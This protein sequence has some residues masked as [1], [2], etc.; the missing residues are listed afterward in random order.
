MN[1]RILT[2][3]AAIGV[4]F[5]LLNCNKASDIR[6]GIGQ[7]DEIQVHFSEMGLQLNTSR[8]DSV[9][10]YDD[11]INTRS[12]LAGSISDPIFGITNAIIYTHF[13]PVSVPDFSGAELDSIV[14]SLAFDTLRK[15]YANFEALQSFY[16]F[17]MR[18]GLSS[19]NNYYSSDI[20]EVDPEP[21]GEVINIMPRLQD[22]IHPQIRIKLDNDFGRELLLY[23]TSVYRTPLTFLENFKGLAIFPGDPSGGLVYFDLNSDQTSLNLYYTKDGSELLHQIRVTLFGVKMNRFEH[24]HSG[25][26]VQEAINDQTNSDSLAFLQSLGG[27][28]VQIIIPDATPFTNK[29]INHAAIELYVAYLPQDDTSNFKPIDQL[30]LFEESDDGRLSLVED[31]ADFFGLP[32]DFPLFFG[33]RLITG[34]GV[35]MEKYQM[36]IT[37]HLQKIVNG[38]G[39]PRMVIFNLE[40]ANNAARTILH[41]FNQSGFGAKLKVTYSDFN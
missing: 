34:S 5:F 4:V 37:K 36:I 24:D 18:E 12:L 19:V 33:G 31:A 7:E 14:L 8:G 16:I 35:I 1:K 32:N 30:I 39:S 13:I 6:A 3:L 38:E 2:W 28:N 10:T 29:S 17:R 15:G 25:T 26:I 9:L 23:D 11:S 40:T 27:T 21:L 41:G 22:S 20:F